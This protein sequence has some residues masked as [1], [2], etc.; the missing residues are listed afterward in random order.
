MNQKIPKGIVILMAAFCCSLYACATTNVTLD[1]VQEN[2]TVVV[3]DGPGKFPVV[4]YYQ[5]SGARNRRAEMWSDWF[6]T[7][8]VAS[9]IVHNAWIRKRYSNPSGSKYP[10]DGAFA[11]DILKDHPKIDTNRFA[12]MGFSRGGGQALDAARYFKGKRVAP[13]FVFA[14]YPGGWGKPDTC[15]CSHSTPTEVHIFFGD[16]DDIET[17]DGTMSACRSLARWRRNVAFHLLQ[18]ATHAYDDTQFL[19]FYC[20]GGR[21]VSVDP[22]P[23]AVEE[24]QAIIAKAIK[25]KWQL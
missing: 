18:G 25:T 6:K 22:N 23:R 16:R 10:E 21:P 20:C 3:P 9:V 5:G 24:T 14:L 17:Y 12:L 8:G 7:K 11:W 19:T 15:L 13:G 4:I 2:M 1:M